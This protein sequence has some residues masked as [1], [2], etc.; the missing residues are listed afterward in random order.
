MKDTAGC[1]GSVFPSLH[2]LLTAEVINQA[3]LAGSL[4]FFCLTDSGYWLGVLYKS[5]L[6]TGVSLIIMIDIMK[7]KLVLMVR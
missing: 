3:V 4:R 2:N 5:D 7:F 1:A 6:S